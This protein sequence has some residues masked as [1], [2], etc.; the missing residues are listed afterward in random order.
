M[1]TIDANET[2]RS[3]DKI[4][5]SNESFESPIR[6]VPQHEQMVNMN[7]GQSMSDV[8]YDQYPKYK[9]KMDKAGI[10]RKGVQSYGKKDFDMVAYSS[11]IMSGSS[12][13]KIDQIDKLG[14]FKIEGSQVKLEK[15]KRKIELK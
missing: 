15:Q 2:A 12:M 14:S 13:P 7:S 3:D 11:G 4:A 9:G 8:E 6:L 1:K 5:N 10:R